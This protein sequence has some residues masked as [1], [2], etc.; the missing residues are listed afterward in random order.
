MKKRA[1]PVHLSSSPY[2]AIRRSEWTTTTTCLGAVKGQPDL[3][4]Q[5]SAQPRQAPLKKSSHLLGG[6]NVA[7]SA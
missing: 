7:T 1:R 5:R 2:W 3:P 6:E 4:D